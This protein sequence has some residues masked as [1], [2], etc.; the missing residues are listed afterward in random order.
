MSI[1]NTIRAALAAAGEPQTAHEV[2][3]AVGGDVPSARIASALSAMKATGEVQCDEEARPRTYVL[4]PS[5]K[6]S[7][8]RPGEVAEPQAARRGR[9]A[10]AKGCRHAGTEAEGEREGQ[11][12]ASEAQGAHRARR[13][14]APIHRDGA[15]EDHDRHWRSAHGLRALPARAFGG[16]AGV[17]P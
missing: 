12:L 14:R 17:G 13:G 6:P 9:R 2:H 10:A 15:A 4:D 7:R 11:R 16:R 5:F 8:K 1:A 3:D